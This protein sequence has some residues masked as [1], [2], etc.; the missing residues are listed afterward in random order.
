MM[1]L[2]EEVRVDIEQIDDKLYGCSYVASLPGF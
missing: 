2:K 1:G